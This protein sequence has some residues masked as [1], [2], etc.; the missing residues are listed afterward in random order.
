V[1]GCKLQ[2]RG[3]M[4]VSFERKAT[5]HHNLF[6]DRLAAASRPMCFDLFD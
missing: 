5:K 4:L 3:S 6:A 2:P 1:T